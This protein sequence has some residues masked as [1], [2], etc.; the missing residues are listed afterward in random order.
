[1]KLEKEIQKLETLIYFDIEIEQQE[2]RCKGRKQHS[3]QFTSQFSEIL[4]SLQQPSQ[5]TLSGLQ[6]A[7]P[8]RA[9]GEKEE[10][11]VNCGN[12]RTDTT[13][14]TSNAE[15]IPDDTQGKQLDIP[16]PVTF[17]LDVFQ[18]ST[19]SQPPSLNSRGS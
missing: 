14:G 5:I 18:T 17:V 1:M 8:V 9:N 16:I 12:V 2:G 11:T 3:L 19:P 7:G 6:A 4:L 13:S 15:V 10:S